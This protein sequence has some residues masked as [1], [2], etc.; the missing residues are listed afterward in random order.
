MSKPRIT[1][2][3]N[4]FKEAKSVRC[5]AKGIVVDVTHV[6]EYEYNERDNAYTSVGGAVTFWKDGK[7]AEIINKTCN[8]N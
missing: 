3:A 7:Y 1:T 5:I 2:V 6:D 4:Y 8:C